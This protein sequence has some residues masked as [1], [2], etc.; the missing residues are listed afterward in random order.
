M[1]LIADVNSSLERRAVFSFLDTLYQDDE[2][3]ERRRR[4]PSPR[5]SRRINTATNY[6]LQRRAS[7]NNRTSK[8][9]VPES[10]ERYYSK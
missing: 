2:T 9:E 4:S 5:L 7:S 3:N 6:S 8:R 1:N 10:L